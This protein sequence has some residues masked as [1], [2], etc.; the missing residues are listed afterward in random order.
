MFP[1]PP[2]RPKLKRVKIHPDEFK[3]LK[4]HD[5]VEMPTFNLESGVKNSVST[6]SSPLPI[7]IIEMESPSE[8][9]SSQAAAVNQTCGVNSSRAQDQKLLN[10]IGDS[11]ITGSEQGLKEDKGEKEKEKGNAILWLDDDEKKQVKEERKKILCEGMKKV[12][13]TEAETK[14][15]SILLGLVSRDL[16]GLLLLLPLGLGPVEDFLAIRLVHG[17]GRSV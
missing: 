6:E 13:I 17:D 3:K 7:E 2:P 4:I 14:S 11:D 16:Q 10:R 9:D 8:L 5:S 12:K 1:P 15:I